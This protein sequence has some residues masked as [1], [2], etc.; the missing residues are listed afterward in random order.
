MPTVSSDRRRIRNPRVDPRIFDVI[1]WIQTEPVIWL[2]LLPTPG[3]EAQANGSSTAPGVHLRWAFEPELGFPPQGFVVERRLY[4]IF[5]FPP[6]RPLAW[7]VLPHGTLASPLSTDRNTLRARMVGGAPSHVVR[8]VDA[9]L[10]SLLQLFEQAAAVP[11]VGSTPVHGGG[12]RTDLRPLEMLL[13]G[14]LDPILARGLGLYLIDGSLRAGVPAD[15][16]VTGKWG[17]IPWPQRSVFF[18]GLLSQR[19]LAAAGFFRVDWLTLFTSCGCVADANDIS[20]AFL[21]LTGTRGATLRLIT[22]F[23]VGELELELAPATS[24]GN[25]QVERATR[26]GTEV[27]VRLER[28]GDSLFVRPT[29]AAHRFDE[30]ALIPPTGGTLPSTLHLAGVHARRARGIVGDRVSLVARA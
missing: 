14:A 28:Q 1:A 13:L 21:R 15:Y 3:G 26:N 9:H 7:Q 8:H 2:T 12:V 17:A 16:R 6:A 18:D 24:A 22:A 27:A 11:P 5:E 4:S 30:V 20:G 23:A 10:G 29:A 25:W 19:A